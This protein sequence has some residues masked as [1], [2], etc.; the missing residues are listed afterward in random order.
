MTS[1]GKGVP[2][3][4]VGRWEDLVL[5]LGGSP[6]SFTG[7][8]LELIA[9]ADPGNRERLRAGF[10][11]E[12]AAWEEWQAHAPLPGTELDRLVVARLMRPWSDPAHL[13]CGR[14]APGVAS[15]VRGAR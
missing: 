6:D 7:K 14:V 15:A 5:F 8:L 11:R 4:V 9:K 10:P 12:V 3:P 13:E 2:V 1:D